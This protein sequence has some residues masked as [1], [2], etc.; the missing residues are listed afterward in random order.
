MLNLIK[1]NGQSATQLDRKF[2]REH[3]GR[4]TVSPIPSNDKFGVSGGDVTAV[5]AMEGMSI[6]QWGLG[7]DYGDLYLD[8]MLGNGMSVRLED[9]IKFQGKKNPTTTWRGLNKGVANYKSK[10]KVGVGEVFGTANPDG[11]RFGTGQSLGDGVHVTLIKPGMHA[12]FVAAN[13][14]GKDVTSFLLDPLGPESPFN[15][16]QYTGEIK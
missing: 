6:I 10:A 4:H 11:I 5:P 15:C 12:A 13:R 14:S 8:I 9:L 3:K 1:V 16:P 7:G 2:N